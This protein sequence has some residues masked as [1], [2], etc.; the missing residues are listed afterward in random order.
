MK[1][2]VMDGV[3]LKR[4]Q[5]RHKRP[6]SSALSLFARA[7]TSIGLVETTCHW[8]SASLEHT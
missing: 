5:W 4:S 8:S 2:Q 3:A 6:V 1:V 7:I